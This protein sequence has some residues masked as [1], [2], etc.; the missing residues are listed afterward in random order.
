MARDTVAEVPD[1]AGVPGD[2][3]GLQRKHGRNPALAAAAADLKK[4]TFSGLGSF[5]GHTGRQ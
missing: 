4:V 5:T 1:Q 2:V 3:S